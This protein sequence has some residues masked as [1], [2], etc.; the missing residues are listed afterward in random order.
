MIGKANSNE[1]SREIR[2]GYDNIENVGQIDIEKVITDTENQGI[3]DNFL[4]IYLYKEKILD[5]NKDIDKPDVHISVMSPKQ[6]TGLID[7][8]LWF[9]N[10]G[11]V[12][13]IRSGESWDQVD[14]FEINKSD[15]NYIK[16]QIEYQED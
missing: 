8:R 10:E 15:A 6:S 7:S 13:G 1:A 9:T 11:A 2:I 16:E 12:I 3:V 4:M 14:Y 5:T